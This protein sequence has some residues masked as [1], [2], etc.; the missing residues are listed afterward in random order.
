M[1]W[2]KDPGPGFQTAKVLGCYCQASS[3]LPDDHWN[4][5]MMWDKVLLVLSLPLKKGRKF[6]RQ[7]VFGH[8]WVVWWENHRA[9]GQKR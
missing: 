1:S 8:A 3:K 4:S 9:K 6:S 7:I 2:S 5:Q